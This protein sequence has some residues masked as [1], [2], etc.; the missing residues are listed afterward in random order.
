MDRYDIIIVGAGISGLSLAHYC[1][2]N[3]LKTLLIEKTERV[4]GALHSNKF[5]NANGFWVELGAHT[6]YNSYRNLIGILEDCGAIAHLIG[7]ENVPFKML[8]DNEIKSIPSQLNFIELLCSLPNI[9]S[10]KKKGLGVKSYYSRVLGGANYSRV[11]AP[12]IN[13]VLSQNADDFPADMLFKKRLRRKDIIKKWTLKGGLNT[14][15]ASIASQQGITIKTGQDVRQI[16]IVGGNFRVA[17]DAAVYESDSAAIAASAPVAARLLHEVFPMVSEKLSHIKSAKVESVGVAVKKDAAPMPLLAGIIPASDS[18]YSAVS[19]DAVIHDSYRG[20]TFHFKPNI[21]N[22]ET[23]L[24]TIADVLK[25]NIGQ[26]E[27]VASK[28][29]LVPLLNIHHPALIQE[30]DG[31]IS[32]KRIILTGNYLDGMAIEDCITRSLREFLRLKR[33]LD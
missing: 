23:K 22:Y 11:L 19:R 5:D 29:N 32:G 6:C 25:V 2:T 33:L 3:G 10:V 31:L 18:F 17:T 16:S 9:L 27:H 13:A 20:F 8:V 24:R 28:E 4:G 15:A 26:L 1:S 12:A 21:M 30:I 14:I 7:R